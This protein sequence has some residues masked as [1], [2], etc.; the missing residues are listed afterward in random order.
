[1]RLSVAWID[2][3]KAYDRVPNKW[4]LKSLQLIGAPEQIMQLMS[5]LT[6][7]WETVFEARTADGSLVRTS[8]VKYR[9]RVYQGDALS[10][11]L[12]C[13]SIILVSQC[14]RKFRGVKCE[15]RLSHLLYMDDLKIH[16]NREEELGRIVRTVER[17]SRAVGMAFGLN[18]CAAAMTIGRKPIAGDHVRLTANQVMQA[19]GKDRNDC[20]RYCT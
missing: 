2:F 4:L 11:L 10:P 7:K 9:R 13:L 8:A 12:F 5:S 19:L 1:M 20:Y 3:Q 15:A 14:L 6:G 17:V 16:A 18:K